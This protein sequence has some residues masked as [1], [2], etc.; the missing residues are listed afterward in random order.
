MSVSEVVLGVVRRIACSRFER[1][2]RR[3]RDSSSCAREWC[4]RNSVRF[5]PVLVPI[6]AALLGFSFVYYALE[7]DS[8]G[9]L[10]SQ[11]GHSIPSSMA[12]A[13][14]MAAIGGAFGYLAFRAARRWP[15]T[16]NTAALLGVLTTTV[17][18]WTMQVCDPPS[19]IVAGTAA[20][21]IFVMATIAAKVLTRSLDLPVDRLVGWRDPR[22]TLGLSRPGYCYPGGLDGLHGFLGVGCLSPR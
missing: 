7:R 16:A 15:H 3:L 8:G 1:L 20:A 19:G 17:L 5:A 14:V 18:S 13:L 21:S 22:G 12:Y 6:P 9:A 4:R 11:W 2:P 10:P